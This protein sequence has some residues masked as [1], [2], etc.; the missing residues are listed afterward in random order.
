MGNSLLQ[1]GTALGAILAPQAIR[2]LLTNDP[3]SS[4]IPFMVIGAGGCVWVLFWMTSIRPADLRGPRQRGRPR[5]RPRTISPA[6]GVVFRGDLHLSLPGPAGAGDLHQPELAL[7]PGVAA[8]VPA[9]ITRLRAERHAQLHHVLLHRGRYW[10]PGRRLDYAAA[11]TARLERVPARMS[12]FAFCCLLT[13]MTTLAAF[14][15]QG[16][17]LLGSLLLVACGGLGCY[18][19]YY[20]MTQDLSLKHQGKVN[21]SLA[22]ATWLTT[23]AFHPIFGRYL[24]KTGDYDLV[25]GCMGWLPMISLVA[26]LLLWNRKQARLPTSRRSQRCCDGKGRFAEVLCHAQTTAWQWFWPWSFTIHRP[27]RHR[28]GGGRSMT[29]RRARPARV[30]RGRGTWRVER[31]DSGNALAQLAKSA[32]PVFNIILAD[33]TSARELD[34]SVRMKPA[35]G[36]FDQGGGLVWRA[37]DRRNYYLCR[38]NP[39]EDN[40][41]LY[42]VVDGK[43]SL[44]Q[45]ADVDKTPGWHAIAV[46]MAGDHIECSLDGKKLLTFDDPSITAAGKIGLWT[47]ADA[48]SLFDDLTFAVR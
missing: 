10:R 45:N 2:L 43:R 37:Q 23:A 39:L 35:A 14:L 26:V 25:I 36:E 31:S 30:Y 17:L 3:S 20:S 13:T 11:G 7:V 22:T 18:T 6:S 48:Q 29:T 5:Q 24:D 15:P 4:R 40:F 41:R 28:S 42:K 16:P 1:S 47:K 34:L 46:I 27:R 9:R 33:D 32:D 19:A 8:K 38:Y 44:L 21:G 12:V